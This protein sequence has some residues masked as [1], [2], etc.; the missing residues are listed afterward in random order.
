M[1]KAWSIVLEYFVNQVEW[2]LCG[3]RLIDHGCLR[4]L[5]LLL[6][7]FHAVV[8]ECRKVR[9]KEETVFSKVNVA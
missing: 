5:L 3:H 6:P 9:K 8:S 4:S 1:C 7:L 2:V